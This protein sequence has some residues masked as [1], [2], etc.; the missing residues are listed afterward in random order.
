MSASTKNAPIVGM[1]AH[2][3]GGHRGRSFEGGPQ[4]A[5]IFYSRLL[6]FMP[7]RVVAVHARPATAWSPTRR[8]SCSR[9]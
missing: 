6:A 2:A 5:D 1:I 9:P 8:W 4:M 3:S 7:G